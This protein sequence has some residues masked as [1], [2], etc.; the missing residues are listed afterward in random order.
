MKAMPLV[1]MLVALV[2]AVTDA[3]AAGWE[4]GAT[5]F[6][7][8]NY[9]YGALYGGPY[10]RINRINPDRNYYGPNVLHGPP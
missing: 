6:Q 4:P 3:N 7:R 5:G 9:G 1:I 2:A 10:G 8:P